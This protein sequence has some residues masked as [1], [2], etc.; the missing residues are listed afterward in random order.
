MTASTARA[1]AMSVAVGI[2]QPRSASPPAPGGRP[3]PRRTRPGSDDPAE[4]GGDRQRGLRR[5]RRSPATNSRLS[6]RPATKKNTA[7]RPSAAQCAE[8]RG[9]GAARPGPT[10]CRAAPSRP[11]AMDCWPRRAQRRRPP[12]ARHRRRSRPA[13]SRRRAS[14]HARSHVRRPVASGIRAG[15]L[16]R[17][18]CFVGHAGPLMGWVIERRPDF[19]AHLSRPQRLGR[20]SLAT[21]PTGGEARP[22]HRGRGFLR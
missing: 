6:S 9:P 1:K 2:A 3:S 15:R 7:S 17:V 5:S 11:L 12:A 19:P 20:P 18:W 22:R 10:R 14:P 4:R 21:G 16:R 13:G 8:T